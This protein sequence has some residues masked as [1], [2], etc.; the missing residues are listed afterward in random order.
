MRICIHIHR[1]THTHTHTRDKI[2]KH[3]NIKSIPIHD[4]RG[5]LNGALN[6]IADLSS[7]E[8]LSLILISFTCS[9]VPR[10]PELSG[11]SLPTFNIFPISVNSLSF[12]R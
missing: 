2:R 10:H 9:P 6:S 4:L 5:I 12:A 1:H 11:S 7:I 3:D 8:K